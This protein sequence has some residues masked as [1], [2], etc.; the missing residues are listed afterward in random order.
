MATDG[1]VPQHRQRPGWLRL[2]GAPSTCC[3]PWLWSC[4]RPCR[5]RPSGPPLGSPSARFHR[6][7]TCRA[8]HRRPCHRCATSPHSATAVKRLASSPRGTSQLTRTPFR[9]PWARRR[10]FCSAHP[11]RRGCWPSWATL[12]SMSSTT[13]AHWLAPTHIGTGCWMSSWTERYRLPSTLV[14]APWP[15]TWLACSSWPKPTDRSSSRTLRRPL[16]PCSIE[17]GCQGVA[18]RS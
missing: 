13:R 17:P 3:S 6:R 9:P 11:C 4:S 18:C 15:A 8:S 7:S 12:G 16:S 2:S 14:S 1:T 5:L 10:R